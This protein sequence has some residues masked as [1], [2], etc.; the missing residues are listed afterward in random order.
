MISISVAKLEI[1]GMVKLAT[2]V[3]R[4]VNG[5]VAIEA[6][7]YPAMY[8]FHMSKRMTANVVYAFSGRDDQDGSR[9]GCHLHRL[10][11]SK[12]HWFPHLFFCWNGNL[13]KL[14]AFD[15]FWDSAGVSNKL[16]VNALFLSCSRQRDTKTKEAKRK[17][18]S[19]LRSTNHV[20]G[21]V[22]FNNNEV[23]ELP[24]LIERP[25]F[26]CFEAPREQWVINNSWNITMWLLIRST[27]RGTALKLNQLSE[28][29]DPS[30]SMEKVLVRMVDWKYWKVPSVTY[31]SFSIFQSA[32]TSLFSGLFPK[33]EGEENPKGYQ[34]MTSM[35]TINDSLY[36]EV[37][38]IRVEAV[39][40]G[41]THWKLC[42]GK[43]NALRL[44]F[45]STE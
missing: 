8:K 27:I 1:S 4:P 35:I 34:S 17:M 3:G 11:G 44:R 28:L 13:F 41:H 25:L 26:K 31:E 15:G 16:D 5:R 18:Y 30:H 12:C 37:F 40:N 23:R 36:F 21:W 43:P 2:K 29:S 32:R 20:A 10:V 33:K 6:S 39:R 14:Q 42:L 19:G 22:R 7:N 9:R 38:A 45:N 24:R